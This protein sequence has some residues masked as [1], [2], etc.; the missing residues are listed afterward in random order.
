MLKKQYI[1]GCWAK[2]NSRFLDS[3]KIN[4]EIFPKLNQEDI[5][6]MNLK[7]CSLSANELTCQPPNDQYAP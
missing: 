7:R 6:E 5:A 2:T 3:N 4:T 1:S